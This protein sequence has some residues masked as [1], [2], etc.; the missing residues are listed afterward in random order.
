MS[1]TIVHRG[2]DD[3]GMYINPKKNF[4]LGFRRLS[5]IDLSPAGHQPMT[6]EDK[7][8]WVAFN[9][10]IYNFKKIREELI[11]QGHQFKSK[12]DTEVIVHLYEE[13]GIDLVHDLRGMFAITIWDER[14]QK[15]F[16][17]R[18]R[19]GVKPLYYTR[20]NNALYFGSEIK[21]ILAN[22]EI[23]RD[24]DETALYHYLT[25]LT[26]PAPM[27]LFKN[28]KK[29]PA[30]FYLE[31]NPQGEIK[32]T[33]YWDAIVDLPEVREHADDENYYVEKMRE[34][35]TD[36][37]DKRMISDVPFGVFLSGGV[38]STTNLALMTKI[39]KHPVEAFSIGF[40][41]EGL[42]KYNELN[43]ARQAV[44]EYDAHGHEILIDHH[45]LLKFLPK[46][47]YHQDEP[48]ADCVCIPLYYVAKLIRDSGVIVAQVGEGSDELFCGYDGYM[49]HINYYRDRWRYLEKLPKIIRQAMYALGKKIYGKSIER[50]DYL[51]RLAQDQKI[52]F[53]G[54]VTFTEEAK[55]LLL[56]KEWQA[57]MKDVSTDNII[58]AY[59]QKIEK[60]KP[61]A[62]FLEKMIYLELKIRLP[63]L[64]LMRVDKIT[65]A[66][67]IESRVPFLDHPFV[68]FAMNIPLDLKIKNRVP[69]YIL[70]KA[71]K[72][73]IPDN[74]INRK[75]QGFGA[76]ITEWIMKEIAP[77]IEEVIFHSG[78][79]E[80]GFFN[81]DWIRQIFEQ[82]KK[83]QGDY[84]VYIWSLFNLSL[85][86][87]YW[88]EQKEIKFPLS[89]PVANKG[90]PNKH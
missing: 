20:Q 30:G 45:D 48:I 49:T 67:S 87:Q 9:G 73:I 58:N 33:Q 50:K 23:E 21:A 57:K 11:Q 1:E 80:R 64:L 16:L 75:K 27:T 65:M 72:G 51:R 78:L 31:I 40:K 53:G 35:L 3:E 79:V 29:I 42:E 62:D 6:N 8:V 83:G 39:L 15:L 55:K 25:F 66:P 46:L 28:I 85:W 52:F 44:K 17:V 37:V 63:E 74:I 56:S 82:H 36:S 7:T 90:A 13:K 71:V 38:D 2:P 77:Q 14:Q 12:T 19:L 22:S 24:I 69:K 70:K 18:D 26:T 34:L 60:E 32:E 61:H 43:Y 68:E 76:P 54:A 47:I 41:G 59:Y 4:G 5:I 10:E 89:E 81:Y 88:I 86:Y 84:S